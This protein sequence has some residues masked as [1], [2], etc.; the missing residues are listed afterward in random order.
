MAGAGKN[1]LQENIISKTE[2]SG[3]ELPTE[4]KKM[5]IRR[6]NPIFSINA[7]AEKLIAK[8]EESDIAKVEKELPNEEFTKHDF[9]RLWNEFLEK[10]KN[11]NRPAFNVLQ[12]AEWEINKSNDI[13]L[14]FD[15]ESMAIEF[16]NLREQ[17]VIFFRE[18]LNNY[19]IQILKK[20]KD[21]ASDKKHIKSRRD[22]FNEM[23]EKNENLLRLQ[24]IFDLDIDNTPRYF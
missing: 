23:A 1:V 6:Q 13:V 4:P 17:F 2:T 15:S 10:I 24:K 9:L 16:E 11:H 7:E 19:Y 18:N 14:S 22:I 20:V 8:K 5:A 12:T 21:E 3:N